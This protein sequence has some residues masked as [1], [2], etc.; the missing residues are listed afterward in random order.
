M[1]NSL[2]DSVILTVLQAFSV[3]LLPPWIKANFKNIFNFAQVVAAVV[4]YLCSISKKV[5]SWPSAVEMVQVEDDFKQ[6]ADFPS[7]LGAIDGCHVSTL[8]PEYCQNDYLDRN[9]N[10]SVNLLAVCDSS[11]KFTYCYAVFPGSVHDQRVF[12]NSRLGEKT[13][14]CSQQFFPSA[15][16]QIV[17]D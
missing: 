14:G 5:I 16:Y 3:L 1:W 17:S 12:S 11:K 9:H 7:V 2:P 6:M 8:A 15:F 10:H 4:D 13:E